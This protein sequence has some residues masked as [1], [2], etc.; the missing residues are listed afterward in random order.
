MSDENDRK[1]Q[2]TNANVIIAVM[3]VIMGAFIIFSTVQ[4]VYI[5][6]LN[7]GKTGVMSYLPDTDDKDADTEEISHNSSGE[8]PEPWFSLEEAA[9]V[10]DPNKTKLN[11]TEI[12]D[13]VSPATVSLYIRG[14]VNG[15]DKTVSAGSGFIITEDGYAVSNA[16]VVDDAANDSGYNLYASV[17][18]SDEM[19]PCEVVGLDNQTDCAV[20][21]LESGR[22]YDHVTLGNS[23]DLRTG[24]L[25]VA[26][27]NALGTL[28]GTVTVG[29]ISGLDRQISHDGYKI[30]VLQTDAAINSGNSG[31]ALINSFGEVIGITNAKMVKNASEGLGFAIP[32]DTVKP[33]IESLINYGVVVN[34]AFLGVTVTAIPENAFVG[35]V[36]GV[37]IYEYVDDGP[38]EQAGLKIGDR[39]ISMDGVAIN[40]TDDI[41]GIRDSHQVGD[42]IVFVIERDGR[43]MTVDFVVGD[44]ADYENAGTVTTEN[45]DNG[46]D[47]N[48]NVFGGR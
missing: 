32:I 21:K 3:A 11:V 10:S 7:T 43:E 8:L 45:E 5:F 35:A 14:T 2:K 20:L 34:R 17:P 24:E 38:A 44:S 37:Y 29:V 25:V 1:P 48:E 31:G 4:T 22:T 28:D 15:S 6:S 16:H 33:I 13:I 26:I 39:I 19:I 27:G 30:S 47:D 12:V 23:S 40:K 46:D 18:G 9:S 36:P 41:I 42:T